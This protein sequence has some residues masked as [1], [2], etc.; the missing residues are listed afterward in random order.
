MVLNSDH[1]LDSAALV[2]KLVSVLDHRSC[3]FWSHPELA[4]YTHPALPE[5]LLAQTS[6]SIRNIS[7]YLVMYRQFVLE[8]Q[9][10]TI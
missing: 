1:R 5:C 4:G 2:L 10:D 8:L 6:P 3:R 7:L 9:R